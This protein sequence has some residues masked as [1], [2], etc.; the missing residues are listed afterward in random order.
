MTHTDL[1]RR[2]VAAVVLAALV[3]LALAPAA[4]AKPRPGRIMFEHF[5][6]VFT[7]NA[8]GSD[9]QPL[10]GLSDY[11]SSPQWSPDGRRVLFHRS[12]PRAQVQC[13][14]LCTYHALQLW[15]IGIDGTG[16][17]QL[18]DFDNSVWNARWSP[19]GRRIAFDMDV[20]ELTDLDA[21][22]REPL[23][24]ELWV[25]NADGSSARSL[26]VRG[27]APTWSPEGDRLAFGCEAG[28]CIVDVDGS[29][30]HEIPGTAAYAGADWSSRDLIVSV[31]PHEGNAEIVVLTPEGVVVKAFGREGRYTTARWSSDGRR[32]VF[33]RDAGMR[34]T[35]REAGRDTTLCVPS[36]CESFSGIWVSRDDGTELRQVTN[37]FDHASPQF[38]P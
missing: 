32:L 19:D 9:M 12:S 38:E 35:V 27:S 17:Q 34:V 25:M 18:T 30:L 3:S 10:P 31:R 8:D 37:R 16:E 13:G 1:A 15:T 23:A 36:D 2:R 29:G 20:R 6:R 11:A 28:L 26:A 4:P 33:V 14:G 24:R 5:A 22:T 21:D 7:V